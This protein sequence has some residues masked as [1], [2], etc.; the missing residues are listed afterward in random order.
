MLG[1]LMA[2]APEPE[3]AFSA[4][5]RPGD[6][7]A[8]KYKVTRLLGAGGMGVVV[9]ADDID[10]DRRVA[11]KFL[12]PEG[13]Q[14]ANIVARFMREARAA[15][16]ITSEHVAKVIEV[17]RL[18]TG[19]PYIVMEYLEGCDLADVVAKGAL[20]VE[21]AMDYVLQACE[22]IAEAHAKGIVHRDLKPANLFLSK[23]ADGSPMVKV[24]DFGISSM[25]GPAATEHALTRTG[26][27][28][29]S[30]YYMSPEQ[31][32]S[33]RSANAQ[34]D[35]WSLGAVLYEL[36][37]GRPP[38]TGETMAELIA[39]ILSVEPP[40]LSSLCTDVPEGLDA[41]VLRCL[42]KDPGV[43]YATVGDLAQAL[44]PFAPQRARVSVTRAVAVSASPRASGGLATDDTLPAGGTLV[45]PQTAQAKSQA[46][47]TAA[48]WAETRAPVASSRGKVLGAVIGALA[49]SVG[50]GVAFT[51][52][53]STDATATPA[54]TS[55]TAGAAAPA[56]APLTPAATP[57]PPGDEK[58]TASAAPEVSAPATNADAGRK[59]LATTKTPGPPPSA[60]AV[61]A[62]PEPVPSAKPG[63]VTKPTASAKTPSLSM[64]LE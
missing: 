41:V 17:G 39:A 61:K 52:N 14:N 33:A 58:P 24:L 12:S 48:A 27:I 43:R 21:E 31:A 38:F 25:T 16:K 47:N 32:K 54:A 10:L 11:V 18:E 60:L 40:A 29:G 30:P 8:K 15:V 6:V 1:E 7:L 34:S 2:D 42:S 37:G 44:A 45:M 53:G 19:E 28:M 63:P 35:I 59:P 50:L 55:A 3:P 36:I 56:E 49:V 51:R 4:P 57:V 5:V 20:P 9:A 46:A 13:A 62:T 22:A 23:R 26:A 64:P